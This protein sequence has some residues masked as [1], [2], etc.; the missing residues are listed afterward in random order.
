[1]ALALSRRDIEGGFGYFQFWIFA[2]T[3]AVLKYQNITANDF[4]IAGVDADFDVRDILPDA[5]AETADEDIPAGKINAQLRSTV[6]QLQ[7][8][9]AERQ[10]LSR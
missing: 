10:S 4:D 1:L 9:V 8:V 2:W 5:Y 6:S 7:S 3:N